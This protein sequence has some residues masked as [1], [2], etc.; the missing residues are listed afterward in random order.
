MEKLKQEIVLPKCGFNF[1]LANWFNYLK[2]IIWL[3]TFTNIYKVKITH[4]ALPY[5]CKKWICKMKCKPR[6]NLEINDYN[7]SCNK[8]MQMQTF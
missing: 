5:S 3:K 1:L 4:L 6:R 8:H 7:F 2:Y